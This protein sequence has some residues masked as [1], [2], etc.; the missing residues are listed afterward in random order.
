MPPSKSSN[1]TANEANSTVTSAHNPDTVNAA[2]GAAFTTQDQLTKSLEAAVSKGL[3]EHE[4]HPEKKPSEVAQDVVPEA[5]IALGLQ[6]GVAREI[7]GLAEG[8]TTRGD[9]ELAAGGGDGAKP[10][11]QPAR[12]GSK[13]KTGDGAGPQAQT[14]TKAEADGGVAA[15]AEGG[16]ESHFS[17]GNPGRQ[18][19]PL[20]HREVAAMIS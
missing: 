18:V 2:G 17:V 20:R 7:Q 13:L 1:D 4:M 16:E 10:K 15:G 14:E 5:A 11:K 6:E 19:S 8:A 3:Q 12:G 9:A